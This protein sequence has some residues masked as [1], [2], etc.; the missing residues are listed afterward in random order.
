[1][2]G[3]VQVGKRRLHTGKMSTLYTYDCSTPWWK[4]SWDCLV[5]VFTCLWQLQ[6]KYQQRFEE[7]LRRGCV[8]KGASGFMHMQTGRQEWKRSTQDSRWA[9]CRCYNRETCP[10]FQFLTSCEGLLIFFIFSYFTF[11]RIYALDWI[12]FWLCACVCSCFISTWLIVIQKPRVNP[13][14]DVCP[15]LNL[16]LF[17]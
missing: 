1:M 3:P 5:A 8:F 16:F 11:L 13:Q 6:L 9:W 2:A 17:E 14:S 4:G 15:S 7:V 12:N 10:H